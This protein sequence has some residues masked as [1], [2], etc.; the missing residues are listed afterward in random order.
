M[1]DWY[2]LLAPLVALP[3][4]LLFA[5]VGTPCV[6][7][8]TSLDDPE[9][10]FDGQGNVGLE[11]LNIPQKNPKLNAIRCA[12]TTPGHDPIIP[13]E[14]TL[15]WSKPFEQGLFEPIHFDLP[16][17][18]RDW[19]CLVELI[20]DGQPDPQPVKPGEVKDRIGGDIRFAMIYDEFPST[21]PTPTYD[22]TLFRIFEKK[23]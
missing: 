9:F 21:P 2:M 4:V 20:V 19:T 17:K 10:L 7:A 1:I 13:P 16:P 8:G 3:I 6:A 5:F 22:F 14:L 12:F 11:F 23:F 18:P 15:T